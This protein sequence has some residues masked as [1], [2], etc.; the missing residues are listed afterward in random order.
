MERAWQILQ[1]EAQEI[2]D[3][4]GEE[5]TGPLAIPMEGASV[6]KPLTS[7]WNVHSNTVR[8]TLLTLSTAFS[9]LIIP[10]IL[11]LDQNRLF[12]TV[13]SYLL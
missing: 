12:Q 8:T 4:L 10:C 3:Y 11:D 5:N 6:A 7:L 1:R 13:Y 2:P 9:Y